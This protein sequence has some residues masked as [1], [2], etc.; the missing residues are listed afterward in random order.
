MID[1]KDEIVCKLKSKYSFIHPLIL[2]RSL[3]RAENNVELFDILDSFPIR[4]PV[5]WD[6]VSRRW[7]TTD[8]SYQEC[9]VN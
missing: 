4:Y 6:N 9:R 7:Q 3:E 2:N 5:I 1:L 8:D